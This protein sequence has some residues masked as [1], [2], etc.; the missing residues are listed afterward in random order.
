MF[1]KLKELFKKT[2][3]FLATAIVFTI[4]LRWKFGPEFFD[5]F[6]L[7]VFLGLIFIGIWHFYSKKRLPDWVAFSLMVIGI[8]GLIVD[9]T[10]SFQIIKEWVFSIW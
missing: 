1:E 5:L 2:W 4:I 7:I 10:T 9:G 6:G 3:Q 8:M